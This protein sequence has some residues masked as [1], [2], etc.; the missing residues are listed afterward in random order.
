MR[1]F[2]IASYAFIAL[3]LATAESS[4]ADKLRIAYASVAANIARIT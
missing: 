4:A 1:N 2:L 3:F